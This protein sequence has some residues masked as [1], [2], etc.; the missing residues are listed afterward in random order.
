MSIPSLNTQLQHAKTCA[1]QA[2]FDE[3]TALC[4]QIV[5]IYPDDANVLLN[6]GALLLDFGFL[7]FAYRCLVAANQLL[8]LDLRP[9][10]N[11]ANLLREAGNHAESRRLYALLLERFPEQ[12]V[13][14][15][16]ALVSLEYDPEVSNAERLAHATAWGHWITAKVGGILARPAMTT[17]QQRPLR[18]GYVS[19]DFGQH[20]VGLFIKDVLA[21]HDPA[22]VTVFA[23]S[24]GPANDW[25]TRQIRSGCTF[26][27]V[28]TLDDAA[29]VAQIRQNNIDILI[30]LSG[31]TAGSR[32]TAFAC[33]PA[34]VQV[35]WLGYFA[36]TGLAVMDAVLLDQW[37]APVGTE[38][39]FTE[40]LVRLPGGR[41]C[42]T[43]VP[44]APV[45]VA[46]LPAAT[47]GYITFGCFNN[48]AKLNAAVYDCWA[49]LLRAVPAARLILKWRTFQDQ[50]FRQAVVNAFAQRGIA[51]ARIELRGAS[52]HADLLQEYADIDIALDPFPFSGGLTSCEALWMGVPVVTWPQSRVVSRQTYAFLAAID[53][54]ALAADSAGQYVHIAVTLANDLPRLSMLRNT[55]RDSMKASPLMAVGQFT[56]Q[57]EQTLR[58]LYEQVYDTQ[59]QP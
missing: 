27:D 59:Q 44:F 13:I 30:D 36:T 28:A 6:V 37:H 18:I 53:L 29:L 41:F 15:R 32:L 42:Y 9:L 55:L 34:P 5:S 51:P 7:T 54:P 19:A 21:A 22:Q 8:P 35:S 47:R 16:N 2:R 3:F 12:P 38:A 33:R 40:L 58:D 26:R 11:A 24:T 14:R 20:T 52:F 49:Q 31:H 56:R 17:L 25:V 57:L 43:P 1:Q 50:E 10:T 4:Q 45:V 46:P 23:Y 48:T 39:Q